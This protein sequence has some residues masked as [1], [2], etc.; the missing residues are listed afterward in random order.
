MA[1]LAAIKAQQG[2]A[3]PEAEEEDL[4]PPPSIGSSNNNSVGSGSSA[5]ASASA[6]PRPSL[7]RPSLMKRGSISFS[8]ADVKGKLTEGREGPQLRQMST[9]VRE[10]KSLTDGKVE[11]IYEAFQMF[12]LDAEGRL[13][14]QAL[15]DYYSTAGLVFTPADCEQM[16][17][18]FL[19]APATSI[20][21]E[22]FALA[23]IRCEKTI[24]VSE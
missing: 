2:K 18:L 20:D 19:G 16:I 12:P 10:N 13:T 21:F 4:P 15:G 5:P 14:A 22:Q 3:P 1:F 23:Y 11:L 8:L 7:A 9:L 24:P 17:S 6:S